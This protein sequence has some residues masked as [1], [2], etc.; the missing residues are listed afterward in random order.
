MPSRGRATGDPAVPAIR[1]GDARVSTD[2]QDLTVQQQALAALRV[3]PDRGLRR[4]R[5]HRTRRQ[6]PGLREALA[7]CRRQDGKATN[8]GPLSGVLSLLARE[9][10]LRRRGALDHLGHSA[11]EVLGRVVLGAG[12]DLTCAGMP[13]VSGPGS[14]R[15]CL[16]PSGLSARSGSRG[17]PST[18]Q[19]RTCS[20]VGSAARGSTTRGGAPA[21]PPRKQRK[22]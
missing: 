18:G 13:C 20:N 1:I 7:A 15:S 6:R 2:G 4:P 9:G 19:P 8:T 16:L 17:G 22:R 21:R 5:D 12:A 14:R 10:S 3:D 11:V